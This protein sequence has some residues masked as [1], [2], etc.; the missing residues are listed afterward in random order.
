[1]GDQ[2]LW[3]VKNGDLAVVKKIVDEPGF[4]V[5][6][7]LLNG[8]GPLHYAADYG[9]A[10]VIEHLISKGAKPDLPDKHGITP[11]LAAVWEGHVDCVRI[12]ISKGASKN[13]KSPDG[14]SYV[15]CAED[16]TIKALLQ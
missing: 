6:A 4:D 5:N 1:M 8:R 3:A 15:D 12:L 2:L 11:L 10:D 9:Q 7:E 13:G 16:D 14:Q